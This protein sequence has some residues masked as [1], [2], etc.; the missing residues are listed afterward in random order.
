MDE[1][2]YELTTEER[3]KPFKTKM[4]NLKIPFFMKIF[5]VH[6]FLSIFKT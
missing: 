1:E 3:A 2:N 6:L 5:V 4:K